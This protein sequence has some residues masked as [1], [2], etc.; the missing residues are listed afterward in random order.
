MEMENIIKRCNEALDL[1]S[2]KASIPGFVWK[3]CKGVAI[4]TVSETGFVFSMSEGDGVII[5]HNDDGTWGPPSAVMFTG[6]ATGTIFG[7]ATKQIFLL[8][9]TELGLKILSG[10]T[11]AELG[12]QLGVATGLYGCEAE[13]EA[14]LEDRAPISRTHTL[15]KKAPC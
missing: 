3:H 6:A 11:S 15:F 12:V 1:A 5:K 10:Q 13:A 4:I 8:A 2:A 7:K 9:M 14:K